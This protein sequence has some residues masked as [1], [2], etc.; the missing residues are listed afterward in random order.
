MKALALTIV[1]IALISSMLGNAIL[2]FNTD[3]RR[4]KWATIEKAPGA[5]IISKPNLT[6]YFGYGARARFS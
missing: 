5:E 3:G 6:E 1:T 2:L 4:E